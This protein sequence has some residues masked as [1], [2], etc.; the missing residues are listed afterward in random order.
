[1]RQ[2]GMGDSNEHVSQSDSDAV[3]GR[4][5]SRLRLLRDH[6]VDVWLS[7]PRVPGIPRGDSQPCLN[8]QSRSSSKSTTKMNSSVFSSDFSGYI[9]VRP[10]EPKK[11][12]CKDEGSHSENENPEKKLAQ[13][14]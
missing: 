14:S 12:G 6:R 3:P 11:E 5:H 7:D 8:F 4:C 13:A 9:R 10:P 1:M 2:F